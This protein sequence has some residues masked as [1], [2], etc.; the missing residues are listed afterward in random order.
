M[1]VF[2]PFKIGDFVEIAGATGTVVSIQIFN[3][4]VDTVDNIKVIIPNSHVT[5]SNIRNYSANDT[6][7][8]DLTVGISYEDNI[9]KAQ[10]I[11]KNILSNDARILQTPASTVAVS[12]LGDSSVNFVVRPWVKSADYWDVFFDITGKLKT[13]LEKNGISIPYPQ[14]DIHMINSNDAGA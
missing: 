8:V 4:I 3:T 7:R 12:E 1:L 9:Q 10:E 14:R 11:I 5:S 13:D 6:R 2:K